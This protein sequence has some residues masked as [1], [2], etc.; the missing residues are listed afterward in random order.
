MY[1]SLD[2]TSTGLLVATH[3]QW[4]EAQTQCV[5]HLFADHRHA[6]A[7]LPELPPAEAQY[8]ARYMMHCALPVDIGEEGV[9]CIEGVAALSLTNFLVS[10]WKHVRVK[11]IVRVAEAPDLMGFWEPPAWRAPS[12]GIILWFHPDAGYRVVIAFAKDQAI[13]VIRGMPWLERRRRESLLAKIDRW[14]IPRQSPHP[15]Q[16]IKGVCA[17]A[18]CL[19]SAAARIR[20]VMH[21]VHARQS[22]LLN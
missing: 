21:T 20:K 5:L 22:T 14:H 17:Q 11:E 15:A 16:E 2:F 7:L 1:C 18:L 12:Q 4:N 13:G 9:C 3:S 8:F 6:Q 19:A 10:L